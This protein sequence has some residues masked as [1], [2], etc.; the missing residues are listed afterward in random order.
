MNK[1]VKYLLV[2]MLWLLVIFGLYG[3]INVSYLNWNN[4]GSCPYISIVP[5]CYV[6]TIGY[7]LA[8]AGLII[9]LRPLFLTGW[10]IFAF[11][12]LVGTVFE[13]GT[14]ATCPRS[15]VGTPLCYFSL[16]LSIAIMVLYFF[17]SR[18]TQTAI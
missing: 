3:G 1:Y 8:L 4:S 6:V 17:T 16:A 13:L 9:S 10:G 15:D 18:K 14:G 11:I 12:A 2:T 5:I 7:A